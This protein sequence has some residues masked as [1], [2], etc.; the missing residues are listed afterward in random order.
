[1]VD[2]PD[3]LK[4][5]SPTCINCRHITGVRTCA[6]FPDGIPEAIWSATGSHREP[7]PG[8]QGIRFERMQEINSETRFDVPEFL[9]K[10]A[11]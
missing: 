9:K 8:D 5:R 2:G 3:R 10:P 6:A 4:Y 11:R 1:M 7:W